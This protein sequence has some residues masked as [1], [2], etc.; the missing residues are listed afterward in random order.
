MT[1]ATITV[2]EVTE[3]T[4][5]SKDLY[6]FGVGPGKKRARDL[7]QLYPTGFAETMLRDQFVPPFAIQD[8][9]LSEIVAAFHRSEEE[10]KQFD[11]D[12]KKVKQL[13]KK[14]FVSDGKL[15]EPILLANIGGTLYGVGGRHR[16]AA[17]VDGVEQLARM[18]PGKVMPDQVIPCII[19]V[20]PNKQALLDAIVADNQSRRMS[21]SELQNLSAQYFGTTEDPESFAVALETARKAGEVKAVGV[22]GTLIAKNIEAKGA[23]LVQVLNTDGTIRGT[24]PVS[25]DTIMAISR[26]FAAYLVRRQIPRPAQPKV[27]PDVVVGESVEEATERVTME[28]NERYPVP[29]KEK[30]FIPPD[31]FLNY[32]PI[33]G[34][35]IYA[36]LNGATME[37]QLP[38]R[39]IQGS[40]FQY[41]LVYLFHDTYGSDLTA[42][43]DKYAEEVEKA[44][45][46]KA[47]S[48]KAKSAQSST[49]GLFA[50][51]LKGIDPAKLENVDASALQAQLAA[52]LAQQV[53]S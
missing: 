50:D 27:S 6:I 5:Q 43:N 36:H 11:V 23:I 12:Y 7:S 14:V 10:L 20:L 49:L 28:W 9:G 31:Q 47:E 13:A 41:E 32:V 8:I 26:N 45:A 18:N 52:L 44:K 46:D 30:N 3:S 1:D 53:G 40:A 19:Q 15:M 24:V 4:E 2:N 16:T 21:K 48:K 42:L 29:E 34:D 38:A 17:L 37:T 25:R 22:L 39:E 35:F 51:V 33:V